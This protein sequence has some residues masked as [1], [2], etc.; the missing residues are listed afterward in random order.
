MYYIAFPINTLQ[1]VMLRK[2]NTNIKGMTF[3][4]A[5]IR[6]VW[7]TGTPIPGYDSTQWRRDPLG[8]IIRFDDYGNED[9]THG[10]HIDHIKPVAMSGFDGLTNLEPLYW[11]T[12]IIKSD[13]FPFDTSALNLGW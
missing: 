2:P 1:L 13:R 12:N 7:N 6:A 5:T 11:K 9:S 4:H 8:H 10:W 3:D